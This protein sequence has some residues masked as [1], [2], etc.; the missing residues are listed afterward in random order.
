MSLLRIIKESSLY[1]VALVLPSVAGIFTLPIFT[2]FLSPEEYAIITLVL[3]FSAI[4]GIIISL[5]LQAAM[6]RFITGFL[7]R[8]EIENAKRY[9][10]TVLFFLFATEFLPS[11]I[12]ASVKIAFYEL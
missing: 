5:Q 10:S 12:T 8:S 4:A 1:T 7:A 6:L 3:T 9:F 2:R 11:A